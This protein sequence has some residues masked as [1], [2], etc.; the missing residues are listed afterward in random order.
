[1]LKTFALIGVI[2]IVVVIFVVHGV[3]T[4]LEN[5]YETGGDHRSEEEREKDGSI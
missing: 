5:G 4:T 3:I 2:A 1:M